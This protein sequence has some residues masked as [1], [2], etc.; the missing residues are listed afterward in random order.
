MDPIA[1]MFS[2]IKN[3]QAAKKNVV[4]V[5][6]SKIKM[7]IAKLLQKGNYLKDA[8]RRGK[9]ARRYIELSLLYRNNTPAIS[10]LKRI[11]KSSRR[12]YASYKNLRPFLKSRRAILILS[13]PKG[14]LSDRSA[15]REKAGGEVIG[16]IY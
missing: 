16:I 13:T 6:H 1:D 2:A 14:V 9:K 5:P 15:L 8:V 7:E 12:I 10:E 3:A 4:V 11:S